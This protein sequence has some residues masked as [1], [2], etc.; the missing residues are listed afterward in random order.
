MCACVCVFVCACVCVPTCMCACVR[1]CVRACV[2]VGVCARACVCVN[3][4]FF[5]FF[6]KFKTCIFIIILHIMFRN[7]SIYN[8]KMHN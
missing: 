6:S 2:C 8:N 3:A 4:R 5:C 7:S 1:A